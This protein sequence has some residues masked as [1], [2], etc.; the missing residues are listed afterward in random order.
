VGFVK[1]TD[2]PYGQGQ[3]W[4]TVSPSEEDVVQIVLQPP[5]WFTGEERQQH[6]LYVGRNPAIVFQV[7]DCHATYE[8]LQNNGVRFTQPPEQRAYGVE[9]D[10]TDMD[11]NTLVFLQL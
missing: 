4:I 7:E 3:R 5:E 10:A 1:R 11:G 9:A 2:F 8:Q 6:L